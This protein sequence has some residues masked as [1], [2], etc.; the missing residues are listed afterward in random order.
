M[1]WLTQVS[2]FIK[3]FRG[4]PRW[5]NF[6]MPFEDLSNYSHFTKKPNH[7]LSF[8]MKQQTNND[9]IQQSTMITPTPLKF[10]RA[11]KSTTIQR[12]HWIFI[13]R[14]AL[15]LL[16]IVWLSSPIQSCCADWKNMASRCCKI[17]STVAFVSTIP[18]ILKMLWKIK[19]LT[20]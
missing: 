17:T 3:T 16:N 2:N 15:C 4:L 20:R 12:Y 13:D 7:G 6:V 11:R 8:D 18:L 14:E 9:V 10:T 5:N 1:N 19:S